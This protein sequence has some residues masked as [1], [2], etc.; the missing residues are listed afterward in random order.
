[1]N[2]FEQLQ[3]KYDLLLGYIKFAKDAYDCEH[4]LIILDKLKEIE[5]DTATAS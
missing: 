3:R 5:D 1:M 4:A 2:D